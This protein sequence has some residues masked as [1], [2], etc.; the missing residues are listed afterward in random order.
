ME[1]HYGIKPIIYTNV[2]IY[3]K[4]IKGHFKNNPLWM[5]DYKSYNIHDSVK[6]PNLMFWQYTEKG[7]LSG[8]SGL[9]DINAFMGEKTDF[10]SLKIGNANTDIEIEIESVS[11]N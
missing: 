11:S 7:H 1:R 5:A 8:I 10:E 6:N 2:S 9:V 4:Y 3:N